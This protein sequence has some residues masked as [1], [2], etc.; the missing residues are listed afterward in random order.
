MDL[1]DG[2]TQV[3]LGNN[4]PSVSISNYGLTFNKV[5]LDTMAKPS[6]VDLFLDEKGKRLAIR[7]TETSTSVPF[8]VSKSNGVNARINNKEFARKLFGLMGW[9]YRNV[10]YRVPGEW[11]SNEGV[12]IFD[13]NA[14]TV[15]S[16]SVKEED[17]EG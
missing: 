16:S 13:L 4:S 9:E 5:V 15:N 6:Y 17:S 1:L 8:C 12:F 10:S 7:G 3:A 14:A 2:F 11:H